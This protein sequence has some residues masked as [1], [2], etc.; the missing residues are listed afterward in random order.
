MIARPGQSQRDATLKMVVLEVGIISQAVGREPWRKGGRQ[1][2]QA[3]WEQMAHLAPLGI[4][5][6]A[7]EQLAVVEGRA[8]LAWEQLAVVEGRAALAWEQL[9]VVEGR[10]ALAW[11]MLAGRS[12]VGWKMM[13][14]AEG[15]W[16]DA[17]SSA[18]GGGQH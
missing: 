14:V 17:G 16:E 8:A 18:A 5:T 7:W 9:A 10:A 11:A 12:D 3:Q 13:A 15:G 1:G 6:V 4:K 2:G